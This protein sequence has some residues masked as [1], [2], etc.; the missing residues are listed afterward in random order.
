[1]TT[2]QQACLEKN[3]D[4][5]VLNSKA[6]SGLLRETEV[7][8]EFGTQIDTVTYTREQRIL[9]TQAAGDA[10]TAALMIYYMLRDGEDIPRKMQ[11]REQQ[12]RHHK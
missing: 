12:E 7:L 8:D 4:T 5:L 3:Y 1:M 10:Y 9:L 2:E 11:L 6:L